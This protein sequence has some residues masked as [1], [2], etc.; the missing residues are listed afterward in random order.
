MVSTE[1]PAPGLLR[2]LAAILYD[3]F[4]VLPLIMLFVALV[5]GAARALGLS[6]TDAPLSPWLVRGLAL[7]AC[8]GFFA[9]FWLK[10]GQTLG[11]QAWRIRLQTLSGD[12]L[13]LHHV[14]L[15]CCGAALS[16]AALGL[17]YLWCLVDPRGRSWHDYLSAT[18]LV[19]LPKRN[20]DGSRAVPESGAAQEK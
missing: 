17:G 18:E 1:L 6:A 8:T 15:R 19:V 12:P 5:M 14:V 20:R 16:A 2:R 13:R 11:M 3:T 10:G 7:L 4:L 9:A